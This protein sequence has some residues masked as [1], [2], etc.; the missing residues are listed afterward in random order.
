L[1]THD[2]IVVGASAGGVE[3]V[4]ALVQGFPADLPAAVFVVVHFPASSPSVLPQ[5]LSRAGP[6]PATHARHGE[7][8][9]PG[10]IYVAAPDLHLQLHHD[11]IHVVRG[12]RENRC[13]PAIDPLFR[14]AAAVYGPR[15][16]GVILSGTLG[17]GT[18]GLLTVKQRSGVAVVQD[19]ASAL[20]PEM[21][22]NALEYVQADYVLPLA[23]IA[24][25]LVRLAYEPVAEVSTEIAS[26]DDRKEIALAEAD[27]ATLE[28]QEKPG[29]PSVFGCPDCGGTLWELPEAELLRFRCRTGHAFS[30][31]GLLSAQAEA[32]EAALWAALRGLE[33]TAA[34]ER[35]MAERARNRTLNRVAEN[36]EQRARTAEQQAA[37]IRKVLVDSK[38]KVTVEPEGNSNHQ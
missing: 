12:P 34:L 6:L 13:R 26:N 3:A 28:N 37:I 4:M 20:F 16:T 17:D 11:V 9:Q 36:F 5:I 25:V 27:M 14:S 38:P 18:A 21:P 15:V 24:P 33:E 19:P 8:I 2:I 23:E 31:D 22:R 7:V 35:R 29:V 32:L 30:A 1:P 10:R